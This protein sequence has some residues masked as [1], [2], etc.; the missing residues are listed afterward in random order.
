MRIDL[1]DKHISYK[2]RAH[3]FVFCSLMKHLKNGAP[4]IAKEVDQTMLQ[5]N[6]PK[7]SIQINFSI[8][9]LCDGHVIKF[10]CI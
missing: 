1:Y 6:S 4:D 9:S 2:I 5:V 3:M 8:N 10:I 7:K